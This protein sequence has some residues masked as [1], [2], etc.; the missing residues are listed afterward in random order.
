M[1]AKVRPYRTTKTSATQWLGEVPEHWQ[2]LPNRAFFQE[3]TERGHPNE[4]MLSVTIAKGVVHQERLLADSSKKDSSNRDRSAYKLV[5]PGDVAYN[6]MRAWQGAV[7][8]SRYKG[9]VS[10][11]YVV[12]RPRHDSPDGWAY[13]HHLF[14]TPAFA[15][16]AERRSHGIT[17]DMWSL[18]PEHFRLIYSCSPPPSER[19]AI[20][21]FLDYADRR[22]GQCIRAEE[23]LIELLEEQKRT[24]IHQAVTGQVDVRTSRPHPTYKYSGVEWLGHVPAHW[25][26]RKLHSLF[27]RC[28]SGTTPSGDGYFG[29]DI[30]WVMSGDLNDGVIQTTTRAVT[31][32]AVG[33]FTALKRYPEGSLVI[34]MYGATIG[35]TG[36]LSRS[37][38]VNQACFV[39]ADP[40]P[41]CQVGY[42]QAVV[43]SARSEL[44]RQSFGGG[45]PNISA[46]LLRGFRVPVP[47]ACEQIRLESLATGAARREAAALGAVQRRIALL[48]EYRHRLIADVA[49]GKLDVREAA[50]SLPEVDPLEMEEGQ[51]KRKST[52]YAAARTLSAFDDVSQ[53]TDA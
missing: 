15:K 47:P 19:A 30:P 22:I 17:S 24:V 44:R 9:I 34:A 40:R 14:R 43:N 16:E 33:T 29:G 5:R 52:P 6:K 41:D 7:G 39:L 3:V 38:C 2:V 23:K 28:G 13:Y 10:P 51:E 21:R 4:P 50:A 53:P 45:Q 8:V 11:A 18:R 48:R 36:R 25:G 42:F 20:V 26:V 31:P 12:Q 49:T 46:Q 32:E 37:A 1:L 27:R 35:K